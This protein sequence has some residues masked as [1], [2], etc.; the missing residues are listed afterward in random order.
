MY[1]SDD[2]VRDYDRYCAEQ[3]RA[4]ARLP[5]CVD[6]DEPIQDDHYY[7]IND[8]VICPDCMESNYRKEVDDFE[9]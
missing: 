3:E 6:C 5:I 4:I 9:R 7:E 8:E 1:Y 2:P